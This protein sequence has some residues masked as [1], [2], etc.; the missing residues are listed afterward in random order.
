MLTYVLAADG[1]PLMPTYNISKVRRMLKDGRAVIAGHKPGFTIRLTYALPD[2]KTP[3]TQKIELC[4]DTGYQHIG[5]S[6]KSKKHEYVH[7]QV[8]TL[9]DE[10][11]H[12]DA[13]RRYRRNRRNRLRYRAP[14]FDNRTHSKKPGWIAPSLQHKADIHVRL[15]STF[16]KVLPICDVYL[17]VGTFD[18]QVL[19]AKEK[20]LPIPEGSDY[21]HGTRY[22]IATLREAVFYRDGYK[23]Q[24]C[25]KGIKDGRI[26]RVHHIGYWKTPSDHTDRMGNLITVCTK[27]HTAANHK[28]GGKL[29]GWKPKMMPLTGAAFMNTVR[30]KI[31]Q[32]VKDLDSNLTVHA[33]YGA[34]TKLS[35]RDHSITKTHAN[36]AYCMG[37][38]QPGHRAPEQ[39]L[40]KKRRNNRVLSK[41]YDAKYIDSRD[42]VKKSGSDLSCGRTNR[43]EPRNGEQNLRIF[44]GKK[45]SKGRISVRRQRYPIQPGTQVMYKRHTYVAVGTHNNGTA[46]VLN[47]GKSVSVSKLRILHHAGAFV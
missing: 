8:D 2:Q 44:H 5:V 6:V 37:M 25:G 9:A 24:C 34:D 33:T 18:T 21:Q 1:S 15:V 40:K 31:V 17:E 41:F 47:S 10:K 14:R 13:Q 27:C 43:S 11:N 42:G 12:H 30:W 35:R 22:G 46:V 16:Q 38:F 26:L 20:G 3:H 28:K 23:C 45:V 29:F 39:L 19:E 32:A 4:E 7:L 36:D